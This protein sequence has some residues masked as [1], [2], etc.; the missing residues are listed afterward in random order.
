ME[1]QGCVIVNMTRLHTQL[2]ER[3]KYSDLTGNHI[4]HPNDFLSR[5]YALAIAAVWR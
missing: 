2:L 1:K 5:L 3:K 4:N